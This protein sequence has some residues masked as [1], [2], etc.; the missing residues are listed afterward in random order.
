MFPHVSEPSPTFFWI[1]DKDEEV[2]VNQ[3]SY[4]FESEYTPFFPR[5]KPVQITGPCLAQTLP[6]DIGKHISEFLG[7]QSQTQPFLAGIPG[8]HTARFSLVNNQPLTQ[9]L[10]NKVGARMTN[11][12]ELWLEV[13]HELSEEFDIPISSHVNVDKT[14]E[15]MFRSRLQLSRINQ[16]QFCLETPSTFATVKVFRFDFSKFPAL[17]GLC[18]SAGF[19]RLDRPLFQVLD[20]MRLTKLF[21]HNFIMHDFV[22]VQLR[23]PTLEVVHISCD[24]GVL[25]HQVQQ[26]HFES[27]Q[28]LQVEDCPKLS[29]LIHTS[30]TQPSSTRHPCLRVLKAENCIRG[31]LQKFV[32]LVELDINFILPEK[33]FNDQEV[34]DLSSLASL[35]FLRLKHCQQVFKFP[36]SVEVLCVT[37][38]VPVYDVNFLHNFGDWK[39]M[40]RDTKQLENLVE[41]VNLSNMI[42]LV[43]IELGTSCQNQEGV[44]SFLSHLRAQKL[45]AM[46]IVIN[47]MTPSR[48]DGS[49][50]YPWEETWFNE[51]F[52]G[53]VAYGERGPS[54]QDTGRMS[55]ASWI[56]SRKYV[57]Y[58]YC[59]RNA[60]QH[61]VVQ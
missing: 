37:H 3:T 38:T 27:S 51:R 19:M 10:I 44:K 49:F 31:D 46:R 18:I 43:G 45:Q 21:L 61:S 39:T 42:N 36:T 32:S 16:A 12:K 59:H 47:Y 20:Q 40:L 29:L 24:E 4:R 34:H 2:R 56:A 6:S 23:S 35:K 1:S 13:V 41:S 5:P 14:V 50:N 33:T 26:K 52:A 7:Q 17:E 60:F 58:D 53:L 11:L 9:R 8:F 57:L 22:D 28:R 30:K 25:R 48:F 15:N 55:F 54:Y